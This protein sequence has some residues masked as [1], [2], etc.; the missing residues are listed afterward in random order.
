MLL[1]ALAEQGLTDEQIAKRMDIATST[2]YEWYKLYPEL[3][4]A[5]REGAKSRDDEVE[6]S[7]FIRARGGYE[8]KTITENR[9]KEGKLV[10][11]TVKIEV[12]PGD[13]TAQVWWTKNRRPDRWRDTRPTDPPPSNSRPLK[14][15]L[16]EFTK[17]QTDALLDPERQGNLEIGE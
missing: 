4:E 5:K 12:L 13:P 1:L 15:E 10:G 3:S 17:E 9:D 14:I 11:S 7:L 2:L 16:P 8:K 6:E